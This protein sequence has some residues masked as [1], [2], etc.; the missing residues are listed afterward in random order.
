MA[1]TLE[2]ARSD[3]LDRLCGL[4]TSFVAAGEAPGIAEF[5]RRYYAEVSLDDLEARRVEDLA[6][7]AR[8]HWRLASRRQRGEI[9]VR[10]SNPG[11]GTE[12]WQSPHTVVEI[13]T[14]DMPFIV[15]SVTVE[16]ER[17]GLAVQLAVH[18][19]VDVRR[20]DEG[21]L[22][23]VASGGVTGGTGA[24]PGDT[25]RVITESF[26][27]VEIE[28]T[29]DAGELASLH[30][31]LVRVLGD[32]GAATSDWAEMV[33]KAGDV[34]DEL[35]QDPSPIDEQERDTA[36]ALLRWMADDHFMFTGYHAFTVRETERSDVLTSVPGSG[37]GILRDQPGPDGTGVARTPPE[38]RRHT[39]D[40]ALLVLTK[41]SA[42]STV[43]R[44]A[45]LDCI[46]VKEYDDHG[47]V[48][49]EQ[50]F[51]GL[52]TSEAYH[53][54]PRDIP[55]LREKVDAVIARAGFVPGGH[56][57]RDLLAIL[58]NY[59]RDELFQASLDELFTT[60][61]GILQLEERRRVRLFV[62]HDP[63][64]R[65][66]SCLVYLPRDR[67]TTELRLKVTG[68]LHQAFRATGEDYQALVSESVLAR[69]HIVLRTV[70]GFVSD[71]DVDALEAEVAAA[72]RS[73]SDELRD[74]LVAQHGEETGRALHRVYG[75]AFAP[76]Y[77][78]ETKPAAAIP[79]IDC[80]QRLPARPELGIRLTR[81]D[82]AVVLT[83][84]GA[85]DPIVLSD[86]MPRLQNMGVQVVEE[87]PYTV[88]PRGRAPAWIER[89]VLTATAPGASL[90]LDGPAETC[91]QDALAAVVLGSAE[92]DSF[93]GLVLA[94]GLAWRE[95]SV[96]RAYSRYLRQAGTP[97]SQDYIAAALTAHPDLARGLVGLFRARFHPQQ[98]RIDVSEQDRQVAELTTA[99]DAVTSLD[100]D[101]ILRALLRL[102]LAT[103]RTN[104]YND[105]P[106]TPIAFKL[107]PTG[108]P[109]LPKP[110]PM[111]E[112]FVTSPRVE[113]VHLRS[114]RVA[115]GGIRWSDRR[116]DFRTEI[117]G[118]MK[119]Q[120]V[121]NAVIV[122][123]GAKGGFVV[124]VPPA[125][126]DALAAE[127]VACYRA[128]ISA[129]LELTDNLVDGGTVPPAGIV[130]Y[131]TDDAYLVVA[132]DKGTATFSDIANEIALEHHFWLGDAFAS[133]GS[134]GF[135]HKAM[136]ITARG[137]WESVKVHFRALGI[138]VSA[139]PSTA[140]GIGDM[141]GDVFGN[142]M[143]QSRRLRLVAAFDHRHVFLDP[144]PDP[145][146]SYAERERLFH[147][148][149]SSWDDYDRAVLA[150]G[151]GI[152]PRTLKAVPISDAMRAVLQIT[153]STLTPAELISA[154]LRAPVDLLWNGGIGTYVKGTMETNFEVG[155]KSNDG[156]RVDASELR[157]RV[158]GE[159]G[160]LGFTQRARVEFA[161]AG[162]RINT[163]AIDN[164]AGV[165]TSDHEVNIKILLDGIVR[166]G[167]LTLA[168]RN[169]LLDEMTDEVAALVLADNIAQNQTLTIAR[170][171]AHKMAG[172]HQRLMDA[173]AARGRLDRDLEFL[174][175][176][177][178][179]AAR[180]HTGG[181]LTVPELAVLLAYS[182][183]SLEEDLRDTSLLD[184]ADVQSEIAEYFPIP[185][186][187]RYASEMARHPLRREII[188]M[189]LVNLMVNRAG[190]TFAFRI[191]EETGA[192]ADDVVRAHLVAAR[193]FEEPAL[194][195]EI[196]ALDGVVDVDTQCQ[197]HLE[198]RK[199][200][201]RSSRWLVRYRPRPL[202]IAATVT[203][204]GAGVATCTE[205]MP[206]LLRGGEREWFDSFRDDLIARAVPDALAARL[207]GLESLAGALDIVD[208]AIGT[209]RPVVEI[210][211]MWCAVG[212]RL[213]LDWLRDRILDD[214]PRDD[215][216]NALA[217]SALRDDLSN[218]RR[219]L[220]ATVLAFAPGLPVDDALDRWIAQHPGITHAMGLL[221]DLREAAG[222]DV[223]N[224]S[225]ALR[226]LRNLSQ[227][228]VH[229]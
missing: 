90:A 47:E 215:R 141:S 24:V 161:L 111:F 212:D 190:S 153:A 78:A 188:S 114:G 113:G 108:V 5:I 172:V 56:S 197:M 77:I 203:E 54:N 145:D 168:A 118:L 147:L 23:G 41:A 68:L 9:V 20:D 104:A 179:L 80:L 204:L 184:D 7:A 175:D 76:A 42:R 138:D 155:D 164:S 112:I 224:L 122:P 67:Y 98:A 81:S 119:A 144:D 4:A 202:A 133:G 31:D 18:P 46:G 227:G 217:R 58:E 171:Q 29:T 194:H 115:R 35:E 25:G 50:R 127:V 52:Y 39:S 6:G 117:L 198:L 176:D 218:E 221:D 89:F 170:F 84:L 208:V 163:D 105:K 154:I 34:A 72:T 11:A 102:V 71:V 216:W 211:A 1:A 2:P 57:A 85:G 206:E 38:L 86:M 148:P 196:D 228:D 136:A 185:L 44:S 149:R 178:V 121:K 186:R 110:L 59:P 157:C 33:K 87:R 8:A 69:L 30:D 123:V 150:A 219:A 132:A 64:G 97:F 146:T 182:K 60:A 82:A 200:V 152:Y 187:R 165:D 124:K 74:V 62:R 116:E 88:T 166:S 48:C 128:F 169:A 51:V 210:L 83:I 173:L 107:D 19:V 93:N 66:V 100:N 137:A 28:R 181:G 139:T 16:V 156:V 220:V 180:T 158:V 167:T 75:D 131:D 106:G 32:V 13:L 193:I 3:L 40:H 205:S 27:H 37:L 143:L 183:I 129:L 201:E 26:L 177:A 15:D 135:D 120:T 96:L 70:P 192:P 125:D 43:H 12:G 213:R 195:R 36:V 92:N 65:F 101:R 103:D 225:V 223:A 79:D 191:A 222:Y 140:V 209:G 214:L 95:V 49:G 134:V 73:W 14:D 162:G 174:P 226:E 142:G 207:A 151:G 160:N 130:R 61:M 126:R 109:E 189:R 22:L 55:L 21:N 53:S 199:V 159:G 94:A 17:H 10:V 91:F 63:Y 45:Y 99:L 229:R